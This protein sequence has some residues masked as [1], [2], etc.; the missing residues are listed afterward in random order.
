M[1]ILHI[2]HQYPPAHTGGTE[3]YT[4]AIAKRQAR[5]GHEVVIFCPEHGIENSN[6]PV[7]EDGVRVYRVGTAKRHRSTVFIQ[8]LITGELAVAFKEVLSRE[9][10]DIVH[11]QH[12]MGLPA[13]LLDELRTAGIPYI[14]TLH[15]YWYGCANAQLLTNYDESVCQG[16]DAKFHNCGRCALARAGLSGLGIA[17]PLVAPLFARR[18]QLLRP[19]FEGAATVLASTAFVRHIY[20]EM[21]FPA[22]NIHLLPLGADVTPEDIA[23]AQS[24]RYRQKPDGHFRIGYVGG[25]SR[26]KGVHCL[27]AAVNHLPEHTSLLIYGDTTSFPNYVSQL[28]RL[29]T[30]AGIRFMG[31]VS[32]TALWPALGMLDVLV[33]PTLWYETYSLIVQEAF[34]AGVPV[35]AS[36]IGVLPDIVQD[37]VNGRLFS[38]GDIGDLHATLLDLVERPEQVELMRGNLPPVT[39][40]DSHVLKLEAI[41]RAATTAKPLNQPVYD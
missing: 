34:A 9:R 28:Q 35:V 20:G 17:A 12:L 3:L 38:P 27:I 6:G 10:P 2:V 37:G 8:T 33:V 4:Q 15:D 32:R 5:A 26:Q 23:A 30:H 41:Y 22:E 29:A 13:T 24:A 7:D 39:S 36:R 40:M 19:A 14:L 16:P 1:R 21:G 31:T 18:N 25:I 11:I